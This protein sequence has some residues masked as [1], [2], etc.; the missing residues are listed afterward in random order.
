MGNPMWLEMCACVHVNVCECTRF[1]FLLPD[2]TV[3]ERP[4]LAIANTAPKR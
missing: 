1:S 4:L 2:T 3:Q